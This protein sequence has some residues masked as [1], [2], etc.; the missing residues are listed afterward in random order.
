[1]QGV[2]PSKP[3]FATFDYKT[4]SLSLIETRDSRTLND[5]V[6]SKDTHP[7]S[8][9]FIPTYDNVQDGAGP[10]S[11]RWESFNILTPPSAWVAPFLQAESLFEGIA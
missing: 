1:M 7:V 5:G 8:F 6:Q 11:S 10:A 4:A 9:A 2:D 3:F